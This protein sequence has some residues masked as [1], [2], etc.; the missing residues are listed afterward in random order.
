MD[1]LHLLSV[2]YRGTKEERTAA[3]AQLEEALQSADGPVHLV[4]LLRA[5]TDLTLPS[6]QSLSALIYAKNCIVHTLDEDKLASVPGVLEEVKS[7]LYSGAFRMPPMHQKT[8]H[9]CV[10]TIISAFEWNYLP[11]LMP[12]ITCDRANVS[13]DHALATL[14]ML[15][16]FIKRFKTP[17]LEPMPMKLE[18]CR[19]L[20]TALPPFLSYGDLRVDHVVL[21]AMECVVETALQVKEA[22][23]IPPEAFDAWFHEMAQHPERHFAAACEAAANGSQKVYEEYVRCLKRIAMIS[24]SVLNDATR[25]KKPPP[26]ARRFLTTHAA[27][28]FG[29]WRR[30]LEYAATS[31][32]RSLHHKADMFAIRYI[33]LC[34]LERSLYREHLLPQLMHV[35][36]SLL[37]PYLCFSEEDESAFADES[38]LSDFVQYM[39]EE[40]FD[41]SE[42]S[43]RQAASNAILAMVKG[44]K[45]FHEDALQKIIQA[46]TL[47]L[48]QEDNSETFPQTF[49]FLHLLSVLRKHLRKIPEIWEAQMAQVLMTFVA[50]RVLPTVPFV[51][52]RCKAL[53]VCQ[54][55]SKAPI[56]S[57]EHFASFT[58][59]IC[60]LV[61]DNDARVRL[62]AIDALCTFL[63]MKR[64]LPYIRPILV[65]LV[66]ECIGFLNRVHTSFVPTALLY[67]VEHFAPELTPVLGKI[68]TTLVQHFLATAFDL[69][70]QEEA[71]TEQNLS[72]YWRTDMSACA[73]LDA[74][75][76]IVQASTHHME[77]FNSIRPDLL[78]L[79]R[80]V[81]EQEDNIEFV[82]K[83]LVIL[84]HVIH[85]SKPIPQ[86]YWGV[87]P[88]LFHS[89]DSG[90]G[91]DFFVNIEEV[92]DN[93]VSNGTVEYLQNAELMEA[94]Y[95]TC[96]KMLF[97]CACG[98]DERIAVPQL[99]EA[100]LHQ[101]KHCEAAPG[102]FDAHLPRFVMLLLRALSDDRI[103]QGEVR[104]QVWIVAA[105][106]DAF[107][108]NAAA[109]LQIIVDYNAHP[110]LFDAL[111]HFFRGAIGRKDTATKGKKGKR[112]KDDNAS[113]IVE[114]LSLL[115]RKVVVLGMTSLLMHLSSNNNNGLVA[116]DAYIQPTLALIEYCVFRNDAILQS[117][118][119]ISEKNLSKIRQGIEEADVEDIDLEDEDVLGVDDA[120]DAEDMI[121][122]TDDADDDDD[123]DDEIGQRQDEGDD[124]VSPIDDV[125]EVSLFLQWAA[126][127]PG[128]GDGVQQHVQCALTK[129]AEEFRAAE[130]TA[131]RY[132]RLVQE[133]DHAM[134]EDFRAR[135]AATSN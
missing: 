36:E 93:Y 104:L 30:W 33:K 116:F 107:Y 108:Y 7:L 44:G 61:Q 16:V 129:S 89:V 8:I 84:L 94:T 124:Y 100:M 6:E 117:R 66:E 97:K 133:I 42:V 53:V 55:Y 56:P 110:A 51:P 126:K 109:T 45:D 3:T 88:L 96:D 98:T 64:A 65:P 91:V 48:S 112:G 80:K 5:G 86:D 19:C 12:E 52:L 14:R 85:F 134:E 131:L 32:S 82:E 41:Q 9:I 71:M 68:G 70:Q 83:T 34:T 135:A 26:V 123:D 79:T 35:I 99:I 101:A 62:G 92:L 119:R 25:K 47:G 60:A 49:G 74:L 115:T 128:L 22:H 40:G 122:D 90:I 18:I 125:C 11:Q 63:E 54:R 20:F 130:A 75:D 1:I 76:T 4:T 113:E 120:D 103:R 72:L 43:Q 114:N 78:L 29:V 50:P 69:A 37:F 38:D 17:M 21:K 95:Q 87:L 67:L 28:F 31:K 81:L 10:A 27:A 111:F 127:V 121:S 2:A 102:L 23:D 73:L 13:V 59:L 118:C 106:M 77:V 105:L 24:Y 58:Q 57:E 15:Y 39:M 132:R 46:L